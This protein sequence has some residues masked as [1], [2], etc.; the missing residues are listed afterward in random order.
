M[1][2][3]TWLRTLLLLLLASLA[4]VFTSPFPSKRVT[5]QSQLPRASA[6]PGPNALLQ[7][8]QRGDEAMALQLLNSSHAVDLLKLRSR[9]HD[10][11]PLMLAAGASGCPASDTVV[12]RILSFGAA[13]NVAAKS[14]SWRTAADYAALHP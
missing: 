10:C 14:R 2:S 1:V 13:A 11:T 5:R 6:A 4:A 7:A 12:N 8:L 9:R 3:S